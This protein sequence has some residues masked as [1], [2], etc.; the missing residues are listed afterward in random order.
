M[1]RRRRQLFL[2]LQAELSIAE[3]VLYLVH[4]GLI[5]YRSDFEITVVNIVKR[6]AQKAAFQIVY[7]AATI[8]FEL[9]GRIRDLRFAIS[10]LHGLTP[11]DRTKGMSMEPRAT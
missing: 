11:I 8:A 2:G 4:I 3:I 7:T 10:R 1:Q 5:H 9:I 6:I